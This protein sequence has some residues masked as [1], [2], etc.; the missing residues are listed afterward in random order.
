MPRITLCTLALVSLLAAPAIAG[1]CT[2]RIGGLEAALAE[3]GLDRGAAR[4]DVW[5]SEAGDA[6]VRVPESGVA[7]RENWFGDPAGAGA[8]YELLDDARAR[9][10]DGDRDGCL[11]LV[12][13]AQEL[14]D[15]LIE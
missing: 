15:K 14:A 3:A 10:E 7:P 9:A 6:A 8:T 11:A 13:E 5:T 1:E 12:A 2:T 4:A